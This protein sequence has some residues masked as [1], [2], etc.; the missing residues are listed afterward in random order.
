MGDP[1]VF[2]AWLDSVWEDALLTDRLRQEE[3]PAED[4][5]TPDGDD[6]AAEF[7]AQ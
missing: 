7:E 3:A 4:P 6:P 1:R 5:A 2:F